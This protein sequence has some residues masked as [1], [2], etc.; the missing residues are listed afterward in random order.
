MGGRAKFFEL[1]AGEDVEGN[2]VDLGVTVLASLGGRHIDDLAGAV[3]DDDE[4][5]LSQGRTLH[6]VGERSAGIG[7]VEDVFML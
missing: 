6:G 1:L 3:L 4:T 2:Q 5:V 7:G